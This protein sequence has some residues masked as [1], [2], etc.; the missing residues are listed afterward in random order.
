M[1]QG[2]SVLW[3]RWSKRRRAGEARELLAAA[4]GVFDRSLDPR[5]TMRAIADI[6]VPRLAEMCVVDLLREDGTTGE[7]LAVA[8]SS[9]VSEFERLRSQFPLELDGEH[10]AARAIR[11]REPVITPDLTDPHTLEQVGS[12]PGHPRLR[13]IAW[14]SLLDRDAP[15]CPQPVAWSPLALLRRRW[16]SLLF[17]GPFPDGGSRGSGRDRA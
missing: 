8:G 16:P 15:R 9:D 6:A 12:D 4:G 3:K 10:P 14:L 17:R 13:L 7:T 11:S 5:H 1:G 2:S